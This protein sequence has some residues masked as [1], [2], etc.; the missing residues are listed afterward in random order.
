MIRRTI[1]V[2]VIAGGAALVPLAASAYIPPSPQGGPPGEESPSPSPSETVPV[3][4]TGGELPEE[5]PTEEASQKAA[6]LDAGTT[7]T[8]GTIATAEETLS[9][10][11]FT[12]TSM[13]IGAGAL[14]VA[15]AATVVVA[16]RRTA[17][18]DQS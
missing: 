12:G 13:A 1:A 15:G 2:A 6:V 5:T 16:A 10:T 14:L 18:G 4:T 9:A 7:S 3:T 17:A 8:T 11:G